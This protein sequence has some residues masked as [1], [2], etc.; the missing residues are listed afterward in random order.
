VVVPLCEGEHEPCLGLL[1]IGSVDPKR[2]HPDMGT[3]FVAHLGA[4]MNRI[5]RSHLE[6]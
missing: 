1:G 5:F 2:Y 4:V 6:Q 3:V